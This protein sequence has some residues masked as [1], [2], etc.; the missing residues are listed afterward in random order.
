MVKRTATFFVFILILALSLS[1]I[2]AAVQAAELYLE[3]LQKKWSIIEISGEQGAKDKICALS[4]SFS[5]GSVLYLAGNSKGLRHISVD[6]ALSNM[7]KGKE[8]VIHYAI[9]GMQSGDIRAVA[10]SD[11]LLAG[12]AAGKSDLSVALREVPRMEISVIDQPSLF[13]KLDGFEEG[14]K[15]FKACIEPQAGIRVLT[16]AA[17]KGLKKPEKKK[18]KVEVKDWR[19]P[20][21]PKVTMKAV[22][23]SM[24]S[25][26]SPR[27]KPSKKP[28]YTEQLAQEWIDQSMQ[29][30]A[31]KKAKIEKKASGFLGPK[32]E[33]LSAP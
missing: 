25:V 33:L 31:A 3:P 16:D 4:N 19:A 32:S 9:P 15:A 27:P 5:D 22:P 24:K 20:P 18:N 17:P 28:R 29:Y 13:L 1:F 14:F 7:I 23:V 21:P 8:Y 26:P 12:R 10:V 6:F 2:L 11:T 30:T